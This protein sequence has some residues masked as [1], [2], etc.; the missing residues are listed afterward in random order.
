M[1]CCS[2]HR[3]QELNSELKKRKLELNENGSRTICNFDLKNE[4]NYENI[5]AV[6]FHTIQLNL[7]QFNLIQ[8]NLI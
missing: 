3:I 2:V 8:F 1:L 6:K 4:K 7:I 5:V